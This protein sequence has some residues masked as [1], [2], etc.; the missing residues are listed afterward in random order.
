MV[1]GA[2]VSCTEDALTCWEKPA[3]GMLRGK[4]SAL[5]SSP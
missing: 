5:P 4:A 3:C 2:I 1:F